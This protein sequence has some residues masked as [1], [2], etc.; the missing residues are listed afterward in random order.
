MGCVVRGFPWDKSKKSFVSNLSLTGLFE[1]R[2]SK[3]FFKH[4]VL[5]KQRAS[6]EYK[7][8]NNGIS[9]TLQAKV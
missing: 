7:I 9:K 1:T 6:G 8:E 5:S 4:D 3:K 2:G